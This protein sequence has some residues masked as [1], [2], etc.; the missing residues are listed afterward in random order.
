MS[1]QKTHHSSLRNSALLRWAASAES[2]SEHP[3]GQAIVE[4]AKA[5]GLA[6]SEPQAFE[7]VAGG[8]VRAT[9]DGRVVL[10]GTTRLL[11]ENGVPL[12]G[13][14]EQ[15]TRLQGEAKTAMLVAVDGEAVG[16]IAVADTV[17]PTSKEAIDQLHAMGIEVVMLTG[18]NPR[19]AQA[20]ADQVGVDRVLAEVLPGEKAA[21]ISRLQG[22]GGKSQVAGG[23]RSA[24]RSVTSDLASQ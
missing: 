24:R 4:A 16:I 21:E 2:V 23:Q 17:K 3:L 18:D 20:I 6:L 19:T 22:A 8:G 15:V 10:V 12:N 1:C 7:A 14:S 13:L 5:Q 9:V 11:T